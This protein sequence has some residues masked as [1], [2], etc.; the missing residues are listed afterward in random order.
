[1]GGTTN[2]GDVYIFLQYGSVVGTGSVTGSNFTFH[3]S[4]PAP[5]ENF[6]AGALIVTYLA[7]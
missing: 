7:G 3:P 5:S 6:T 4:S 1:M 2:V